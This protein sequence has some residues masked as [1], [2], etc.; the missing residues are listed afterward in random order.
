M[1]SKAG[2]TSV[3]LG[4]LSCARSLHVYLGAGH[5]KDE[6]VTSELEGGENHLAQ[7]IQCVIIFIFLI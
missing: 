5:I 7:M 4:E 6:H 1:T 2:I 3:I